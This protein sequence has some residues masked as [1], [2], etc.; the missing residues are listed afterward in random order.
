MWVRAQRAKLLDA[1]ELDRKY[2]LEYTVQKPEEDQPR[3]FLSA[4]SLGFN[5]RQARLET[6]SNASMLTQRLCVHEHFIACMAQ[7]Q[8][9][10]HGDSAVPGVRAVQV[11]TDAPGDDQLLCAASPCLLAAD[12]SRTSRCVRVSVVHTCGTLCIFGVKCERGEWIMEREKKMIQKELCVLPVL[13]CRSQGCL[14][15]AAR[16]QWCKETAQP[17]A[18]TLTEATFPPD[19]G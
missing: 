8:Q 14:C 3:H 19:F 16:A 7:V 9:A 2:F 15:G 1:R 12:C 17:Y 5:G 10:V 18:V 4:V 13:S 6:E 11:S